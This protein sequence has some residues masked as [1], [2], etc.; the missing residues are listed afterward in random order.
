MR[1]YAIRDSNFK[2]KVGEKIKLIRK[3]AQNAL[4]RED[5]G[6]V[7]A[8]IFSYKNILLNYTKTVKWSQKKSDMNRYNNQ[9]P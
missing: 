1:C 6:K 4:W 5:F 3:I 2:P 8:Y 9:S 7:R